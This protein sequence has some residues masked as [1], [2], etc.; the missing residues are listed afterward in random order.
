M[1]TTLQLTKKVVLPSCPQ[2][3]A[4]TNQR[5]LSIYFT[6]PCMMTLLSLYFVKVRM[7]RCV[8][9]ESKR[10]QNLTSTK[11]PTRA[12]NIFINRVL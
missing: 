2:T 9:E 4:L 11:S 12:F 8:H 3:T 10:I 1:M 6:Q 7:T 5:N